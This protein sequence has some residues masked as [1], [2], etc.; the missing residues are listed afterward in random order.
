[1]TLSSGSY[2][3]ADISDSV[4]SNGTYQ[5]TITVTDGAGNVYSLPARTFVVT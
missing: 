2:R 3:S 5:F 1:M 4:V